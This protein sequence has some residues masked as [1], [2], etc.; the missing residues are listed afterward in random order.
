MFSICESQ[1]LWNL[2]YFDHFLPTIDIIFETISITYRRCCDYVKKIYIKSENFFGFSYD[3]VHKD[4]KDEAKIVM[5]GFANNL[6]KRKEKSIPLFLNKHH[7]LKIVRTSSSINPIS[8]FEE[9]ESS[10]NS[11][12][13]SKSGIDGKPKF[14]LDVEIS[15]EGT[16]KIDITLQNFDFL[17]NLN[18]L[19]RLIGFTSTDNS[20]VLITPKG[21]YFYY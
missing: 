16:K 14:V 12:N 10:N 4:Q 20:I 9:R 5:Q 17:L 15:R 3:Y 11:L 19:F 8:D 2:Q 6:N 21:F 1:T 13:R 18:L 7:S